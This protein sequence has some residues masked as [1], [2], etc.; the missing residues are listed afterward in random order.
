MSA[1][2]K[3]LDKLG[4]G[5][6]TQTPVR[7]FAEKGESGDAAIRRHGLDPDDPTYLFLVIHFVSPED[8]RHGR[9]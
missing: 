9:A 8:V 7:L 6:L 3:R 1:L 2:S 5:Q 4:H